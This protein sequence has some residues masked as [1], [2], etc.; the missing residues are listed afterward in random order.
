MLDD[1][2]EWLSDNLRYILL[3]LAAILILV[4]GFCVFRL[5]SSSSENNKSSGNTESEIST[6]VI[7]E[8]GTQ[9]GTTADTASAADA[10]DLVK[11]DSAILALVKKY[12][13]A[14]AAKDVTTLAAI[15]S[16]WNDE[17]EKSILQNDVIESYNNISTYSKDGPLDKSYIVYTYYECKVPNIDTLAPSLSMLYLTTDA[18]GNLIVSDRN[19][20]QEV[21]DFI[22]TMSTDADVQALRTDVQ[23]Q[24][25]AAV[26]SDPALKELMDTLDAS[27]GE[28]T[29]NTGGTSGSLTA[30]EAV[31]TT[32]LNVRA[33]PSTD[34]AIAGVATSGTSVTVLEDAGD[35]WS[36]ISY[37]AESYTIEG[38][39]RTEYL[40]SSGVAGST[41]AAETNSAATE[42]GSADTTADNA[43]APPAETAL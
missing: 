7:T 33:E 8:A 4:I 27:G 24:Y 26:N 9:A 25:E 13:T 29:E 6:E 16:P 12:Y 17:V 40:S 22:E 38:Y 11:D 36:K 32:E 30:G 14:A 15:V 5:V 18:S 19:S 28:N 20:S 34:A 43:A 2:R 42:A 3:G 41:E 37:S 23:K 10:S 1:F 21:T 39:V 35:G 31:T